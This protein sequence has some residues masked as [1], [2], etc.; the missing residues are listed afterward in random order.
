MADAYQDLI[1]AASAPPQAPAAAAPVASDAYQDLLDAASAAQAKLDAQIEQLPSTVQTAVASQ[2]A[3]SLDKLKYKGVNVTMGGFLEAAGI[4][5]SKNIASD[6]GSSFAKIPFNNA[7]LSRV[8]EFRG[9]A[10][11]SRARNP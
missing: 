7:P 5:R 11:Q 8:S 3:P 10:R 6:I 4:Y 1:A 2:P 9:T